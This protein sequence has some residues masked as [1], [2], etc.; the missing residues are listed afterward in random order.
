MEKNS[1]LIEIFHFSFL[2]Q[3]LRISDLRLYVLKGGVNLRF[4]FHSPRYSED[5]DM[6]VFESSV[7]TLKKNGYKVL[8][9]RSFIRRL[10][11]FGI[12]GLDVNDPAKGKHTETTQRFRLGLLTP[13]GERLSTKVEFSRRNKSKKNPKEILTELIDSEI[14]Y[15]YN[16]R[17]YRCQHYCGPKAVLQKIQ[18]LAGRP[19]TQ[20]RDVFDLY[21]L[22]LAGHTQNLKIKN[23]IPKE[24]LQKAQENTLALQFDD[25]K[26]QVLEFLEEA[27]VKNYK[28]KEIW[29]EIQE[30]I[31]N[32][33]GV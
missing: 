16:R 24:V 9:D 20:A 12:E 8:K 31:L 23:V 21:Q 7:Q 27:H 30:N 19:L 14:A 15:R 33:L 29:S 1:K 2:E 17:S 5:M 22:T 3:L 13:A 18:A 26:G 6:D 28:N 32:L 11:T 4:F 10:R 25:F